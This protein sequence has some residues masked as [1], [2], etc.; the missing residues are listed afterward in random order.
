MATPAA[1]LLRPFAGARATDT[2]APWSIYAVLF[3][4][5]SVILGVMWD[6]SWHRTIGRDT[7]WTP[8]HMG[9][10]LGGVVA[11]LTSGIVAL[12][13]T[14]A[15]TEAERGTAVRFWGFRAPLG[16]WVCI[17]GAFAMLTSAPF[18]DWWHNAY[19]LDVKIISP[20]HMLL[21]AGIAAIQTGAMLMA[22]A[23]QN[24][25][26]DRGAGAPGADSDRRRLGRLYLYGAGLL[27]L[28]AAT[29]ATEHTQR[30]DL[31]TSHVYKVSAGVFLFFLI[32]AARASVTRWP[33]TTIAAVY[34]GFTIL[35]ILVLPLFAAQAMLGPIY[36][37]VDRFMPPDFPLL[38]IVPAF[39]LDLLLLRS[40]R[41]NDW[42][43]AALASVAFVVAFVAVQ[44]PFADFLMSPLARN[45]F[46]AT[47]LI[48][49]S[50]PPAMQ[51]RWF[52]LNPADD[53]I[54]GLPIAMAIGYVS[55]RCGLWWGN[56]MARVRR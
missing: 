50:I 26:E 5:T 53:L 46:F 27:L 56:W 17:W 49:Y 48:P 35:M 55:A 38:L 13:T 44:F 22:L 19:G 9:I 25:A 32:S 43:F 47:Q 3:A 34:T 51:Q 15:G 23:W 41:M 31:H 45:R 6:I 42:V 18:D 11:G 40:G 29:V 24:R 33:A 37:P 12:R 21:A 14:F 1:V 36:V 54:V 30:W 28:L 20:P 8:A 52:V 16:A 39:A 4:S 10:Y 7:F 2:R